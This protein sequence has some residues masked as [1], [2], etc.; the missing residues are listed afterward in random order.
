MQLKVAHLPGSNTA[1]TGTPDARV[2][3][4]ALIQQVELAVSLGHMSGCCFA[5]LTD[6]INC[7]TAQRIWAVPRINMVLNAKS[8][9]LIDYIH[10]Q[11]INRLGFHM[12]YPAWFAWRKIGKSTFALSLSYAPNGLEDVNNDEDLNQLYAKVRLTAESKRVNDDNHTIGSNK[13]GSLASIIMPA[14][15]LDLGMSAYQKGLRTGAK[16]KSLTQQV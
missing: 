7:T 1:A 6:A 5:C 15:R 3:R 8:T 9:E 4:V 10:K 13:N 2:F 14:D 16:I 12:L 11:L